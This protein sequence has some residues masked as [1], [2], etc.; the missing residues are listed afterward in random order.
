MPVHKVKGG[1]KWGRH[2][3]VYKNKAGAERQ[4]RAIYASGYRGDGPEQEFEIA[5]TTYV[6]L[7]SKGRIDEDD[8]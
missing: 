5:P 4:A 7:Y 1:Y 3:K 8:E 6:D 2:G